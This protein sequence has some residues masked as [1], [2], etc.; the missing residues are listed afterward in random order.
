MEK[1]QLLRDA[2]A[3][4][5]GDVIAAGL[6]AANSAYLKLI[7]EMENH[8]IQA[9]WRYY[10]DGKAW[11]GKVQYRWTTSRG[12]QKE[13][14]VFWL[15]VWEGFFRVGFTFPEKSRGDLS[16]L[17]L[18]DETKRRIEA[19]EQIGKMKLFSLA[20]DLCSDELFDDIFALVDY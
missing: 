18:G 12:T 6:G 1:K 19:S 10:N 2:T 20:F 7:K 17:P 3:E 4:P 16:G 9:D 11:L 15:S 5:T 14:T 13:K 8:G